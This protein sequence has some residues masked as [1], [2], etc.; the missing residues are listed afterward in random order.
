MAARL[1]QQFPETFRW[2]ASIF[3]NFVFPRAYFNLK[4]IRKADFRSARGLC[5]K[6]LS[7]NEGL[8]CSVIFPRTVLL[9]TKNNN[10]YIISYKR[11]K[12]SI[13][14]NKM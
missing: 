12:H 4:L 7:F 14:Y 9:Q 6:Y 1:L 8:S 10:I 3:L 2:Q 13:V 5:L 11:V